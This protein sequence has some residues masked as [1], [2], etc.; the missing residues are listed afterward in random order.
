MFSQKCASVRLLQEANVSREHKKTSE[1]SKI[2]F[3]LLSIHAAHYLHAFTCCFLFLMWS[4]KFH[5]YILHCP[6][7]KRPRRRG[8]DTGLSAPSNSGRWYRVG[9]AGALLTGSCSGLR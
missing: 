1:W 7:R 4:D 2:S 8:I 5:V 9:S 3:S 6:Q